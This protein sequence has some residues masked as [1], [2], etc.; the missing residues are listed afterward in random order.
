MKTKVTFIRTMEND[1]NEQCTEA[2]ETLYVH[3]IISERVRTALGD[4]IDRRYSRKMEQ[5][6]T[7]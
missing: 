2:I 7:P 1:I 5:K 3:G 4:K 6:E